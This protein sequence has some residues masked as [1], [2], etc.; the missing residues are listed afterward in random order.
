VSTPEKPGKTAGYGSGRHEAKAEKFRDQ[1]DKMLNPLSHLNEG[2]GILP[3]YS[4]GARS[5]LKIGGKPIAVCMDFRWTV[6]YNPT[7]LHTIDTVFGWDI[8]MGTCMIQA[9]MSKFMDPTKGPEVDHLIPIM[10][11]AVHAPMVEMQVLDS[12]GTSLFFSKGM[13]VEV[14]PQISMNQVTNISAKFIGI[15]YQH[16]VSQAFKPYSVTGKVAGLANAAR[17]LVSDATGGLI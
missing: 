2:S 6:N 14:S 15:S 13:F 3:Y 5:L 8:D 16:Y 12:I 9:S 10:A 7:V 4:T 1:I 11:T 17:N